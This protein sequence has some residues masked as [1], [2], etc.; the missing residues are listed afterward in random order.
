MRAHALNLAFALSVT[1]TANA[2]TIHVYRGLCE[3]SAAVFVDGQHFAVASDETNVL[4]IYSRGDTTVGIESDFRD[5][6]GHD[7]SDLE[8]AARIDNRVYWISSHSFNSDGE[9]KKKRKVIFATDIVDEN[10]TLSLKAASKTAARASLRDPI[11]SAAGIGTS[12][13]NIEGLAATAGGELLVGLRNTLNG[14]AIVVPF[15]NPAKVVEDDSPPAFGPPFL[16]DLGGKGV[17]SL[18]LFGDKYLIVAGP[19]SDESGFALY[20]W[21]GTNEK[22]DALNST[23]LDGL[24]PEAMMVSRDQGLFRS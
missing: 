15:H 3:A 8:A 22:V 4:R 20:S 23:P 18:E 1:N 17:R 16:L 21:S 10:G 12:E 11:V 13:L 5:F 2:A 9:D 24:R 7:K 19:V 14:K 6:S